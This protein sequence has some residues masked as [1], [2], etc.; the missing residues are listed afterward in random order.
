M[1]ANAPR[2]GLRNLSIDHDSLPCETTK[3]SR[4]AVPTMDTTQRIKSSFPDLE[5]VKPLPVHDRP[6]VK[7]SWWSQDS[8]EGASALGGASF[9]VGMLYRR[10]T[11]E[12]GNTLPKKTRA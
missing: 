3:T 1:G 6:E 5:F 12:R 9:P 2:F 10:S 7:E 4:K 8:W 11:A